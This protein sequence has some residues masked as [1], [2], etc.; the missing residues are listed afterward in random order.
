[1]IKI[2]KSN[3][4]RILQHMENMDIATITAF[5]TDSDLGF[6]KTKIEKEIKN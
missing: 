2:E 1:M 5:R 6:S 3:L 4:N